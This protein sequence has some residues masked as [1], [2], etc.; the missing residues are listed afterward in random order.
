EYSSV[1]SSVNTAIVPRQFHLIRIPLQAAAARRSPPARSSSAPELD[2]MIVPPG[3]SY[4]VAAPSGTPRIEVEA[5][6]SF[7][8]TFVLEPLNATTNAAEAGGTAPRASSVLGVRVGRRP[9]LALLN[10]STLPAAVNGQIAPSVVLLSDRDQ[11]FLCD[12]FLFHVAI[13]N[14]ARVGPPPADLLASQKKCPVCLTP[15]TASSTVFVCDCGRAMHCEGKG[16][17]ECVGEG[18]LCPACQ[19]PVTLKEGYGNLPEE[20]LA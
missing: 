13:Y 12:E 6:A 11:I 5:P 17:L 4:L 2:A 16:K 7:D 14:L 19:T 1:N 15:F 20:V 18:S 3:V 8:H 9:L 10:T